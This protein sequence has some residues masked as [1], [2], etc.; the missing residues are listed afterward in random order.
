MRIMAERFIPR[1]CVL[2]A[3][4][5][6]CDAE[7]AEAFRLGGGRPETVMINEL[8]T[9]EKSLLNYQILALPGGFAYGDDLGSG[10]VLALELDVYLRDQIHEFTERRNGLVIGICN[11]FQVLTRTGLLPFGTIGEQR[12][13]LD[14]NVSGNF[15]C[16]P[17]KLMVE[18]ENASQFL[19]GMNG[20][21]EYQVAH[22]EGNF[23]TSEADLQ[24]IE[25]RGLVVFRYCNPVTGE[26]TMEYPDNPN[27]AMNAIAG[28]CDPS[29]KILGLMPHPERSIKRTQYTNWRRMPA[30]FVPEGLQIF[31]RMVEY[32]IE[33]V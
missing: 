15:R 32:V 4:G 6:N 2:K 11:G 21:V 1:V 14:A 33:G 3:D 12:A 31:Q 25:D 8:K 28:I 16:A 7:T 18:T 22:G 26:P 10:K 19:K 27:G 23:Q 24:R 13:T 30:D 20:T 29:G 5:T 17:V 9:R